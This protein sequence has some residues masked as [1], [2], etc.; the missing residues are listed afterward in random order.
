MPIFFYLAAAVILLARPSSA[1]ALQAH[2]G[3]EGLVAHQIGHLLFTLAIAYLLYEIHKS[4]IENHGWREFK[5][6]LWL[7][8][9]W[10][11]LTFTGHWMREFVGPGKFVMA[12]GRLAGM[13]VDGAWD[14]L[15]YLTRLDHLLLVPAFFML[16]LALREWRRRS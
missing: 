10:N 8:I 3:A 14:F 12:D 5:Y 7:L 4:R 9:C 2:G 6:F 1:L 15:F 13:S 16:F 11:L